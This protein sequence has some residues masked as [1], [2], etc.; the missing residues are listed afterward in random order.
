M[1][2]P[3]DLKRFLDAQAPVYDIVLDELKEGRKRT[4]WMWFI[5]P[6]AEGLSTS[7]TSR[8]FAIRSLEHAA[9]YS[10]HPVLGARLVECTT[11]VS[12]LNGS[13]AEAIFGE[14]DA[15]K[16]RSS[17]TLFSIS[18]PNARLIEEA[19]EKFFEGIKDHL[20]LC[21]AEEWRQR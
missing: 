21:L 1:S 3:I 8:H 5:F 9:Q 7:S 16:F 10:V 6:Q 2:S 4:H 11:T 18:S 13:S 20:T 19:L 15:A 12:R 14:V 17:M